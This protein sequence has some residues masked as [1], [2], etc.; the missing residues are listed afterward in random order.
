[1]HEIKTSVIFSN[2]SCLCLDVTYYTSKYGNI[3]LEQKT[4]TIFVDKQI[5]FLHIDANQYVNL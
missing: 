3:Q 5:L 2:I 1:M 4:P